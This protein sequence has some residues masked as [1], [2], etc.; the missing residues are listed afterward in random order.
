MALV[1]AGVYQ[2]SFQRGTASLR[3]ASNARLDLFASVVEA[4][5]RRLEPVPATVQLNPVVVR[6]LRQPSPAQV[7]A[8]NDYLARLNAHLG[9]AAVYVL[10]V[11]GVVRASSNTALADD[12]LQGQD[13]SYRPYFLE[14]LAGRSTRHFAM[15]GAGE[16]G[17]YAAHPIY[18]GAHVVGVAA[19]KIGLEV[20]EQ[21]WDMLGVPALV[22]DAN[23]VV[24]LSSQPQWRYT[25]MAPLSPEQR[26][27][28][29]LSRIYGA[30]RLQAFP[31]PVQL[32]VNEDSQEMHGFVRVAQ[33]P[34]PGP[35]PS[36]L[37]PGV[38][39]Y[40]VL[41][42]SLD[43]M[44]WRV[45]T[46]THLGG[47]RQ[48]AL[49]D[50]MGGALVVA[51]LLLLALYQT[52][53][54]RI[55]RQKRSAKRLLEQ[56]N[57]ELEQ[58]VQHRTQ[59]LTDANAQLRKEVAEREHTE[60]TLR[61]AQDELVHAGKMAVLGQLAAS[62]THELTQPL[63][64]IRT[65]AGNAAEFLR[66][67]NTEAAQENLGHVARLVGQMAGIIEPLKGFARKSA[68]HAQHTDVGR[69]VA[70]ALFLYQLRLRHEQVAVDNQVGSG[71]W[72][73]W[74][75]ANRLEQVLINLIGNALDAMREAPARRLQ[76]SAQA[77]TVDGAAAVQVAVQ[78]SGKGLSETDLAHLFQP[79]YTTK[80]SGAGLG[81]GLVICRD[82]AAEF[83]GELQARNA[84][85]AGA[86]FTLT[87]A[88]A[89]APMPTTTAPPA[90]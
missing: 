71:A 52:Q 22:A 57:A 43:G 87:I 21:T 45:L 27:D 54:R 51:V 31:L 33:E 88:L 75:D 25:A 30:L 39:G 44:D 37:H 70:Q 20:L 86:C 81:L 16:A 83:G 59:E 84:E 24:I 35:H 62:I 55:E 26:V 19:I 29:H 36:G 56:A 85:G 78:D 5:V 12:S 50:G 64:G 65:L 48:Q 32:A 15:G 49:I 60:K 77:C 3:E 80:P 11:R 6:L 82:I 73:V 58:Q 66:R 74:C 8:A 7:A 23:Q 76:I 67:G 90:P 1:G 38:A 9:S 47:V 4:R 40:M 72:T 69:V 63:G 14:A 18:D 13:V 17:Y 53:R 61:A 42:R 79:F 89:K 68:A 34:V 2:R 46:F 41:G 10:D 28:L